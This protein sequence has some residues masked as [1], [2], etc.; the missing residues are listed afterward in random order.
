MGKTVHRQG[1]SGGFLD[2]KTSF[3]VTKAAILLMGAVS[4]VMLAFGPKITA[5]CL[6]H[7]G[8][9]LTGTL[10]YGISLTC[11]YV[12]GCLLLACLFL[13]W[14]LIGRIGEGLVFTGENVR[15]LVLLERVVLTASLICLFAGFTCIFALVLIGLMA[16]FMALIIRVIRGA[17][18]KAVLMKEELDLT[19]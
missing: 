2:E 18:A 16:G 5:Y 13:L 17:F 12:L 7:E 9:L 10:R 6:V 1:S 15:M 14:K 11:G 19:V 8:P 4:L 3:L